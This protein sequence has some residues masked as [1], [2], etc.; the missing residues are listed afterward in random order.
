[1]SLFPAISEKKHRRN[2]ELIVFSKFLNFQDFAT[3]TYIDTS[4]QT[5]HIINEVKLNSIEVIAVE[6]NI[7][8]FAA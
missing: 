2:D 5:V 7:Q 6:C 8:T 3:Y 4:L 1:M